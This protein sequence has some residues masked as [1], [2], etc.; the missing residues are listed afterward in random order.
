MADRWIKGEDGAQAYGC[1]ITWIRHHSPE[2][3][4][5]DGWSEVE[6][7]SL[8]RMRSAQEIDRLMQSR[9]FKHTDQYREKLRSKRD[10]TFE[11]T[12]E[13]DIYYLQADGSKEHVGTADRGDSVTVQTTVGHRFE[14]QDGF[15]D[16]V[17]VYTVVEGSLHQ[18]VRV[19]PSTGEL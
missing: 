6:R 4:V 16:V 5:K 1:K 15:G 9:G 14:I 7:I 2:L 8:E 3:I 12:D 11:A 17:K 10:V 13:V 19:N 18:R